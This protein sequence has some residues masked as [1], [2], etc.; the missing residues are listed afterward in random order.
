V[1]DDDVV[2]H[3]ARV[4]R[5]TRYERSSGAV[6][7]ALL[8]DQWEWAWGLGGVLRTL[9][10]PG[11]DAAVPAV[12]NPV[13]AHGQSLGYWGALHYLLLYRLG[14]ERPH[15]GLERWIEGGQNNNDLT[16]RVIDAVRGTDRTLKRYYA[17]SLLSQ[18]EYGLREGTSLTPLYLSPEGLLRTRR[19]AALSENLDENRF[20]WFSSLTGDP[21][22]LSGHYL[23]QPKQDVEAARLLVTDGDRQHAVLLARGMRWYQSL[24]G[25][26]DQLPMQGVH[27][28]KVEVHVD[29]V[30]LIGTFRRSA[31][32][33][34]WFT[35]KHSTH[36]MGNE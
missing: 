33:G 18:I 34:L 24:L 30:G 9:T 14:W 2:V 12:P 20:P 25:F 11:S 13:D 5:R 36:M 17:W 16:L 21:L 31:V 3:A 19:A 4:V 8:G 1:I 10:S 29:S 27:S 23:Q 7:Y 28:W 26:D 6:S 35:G 15:L 32:T 22:H